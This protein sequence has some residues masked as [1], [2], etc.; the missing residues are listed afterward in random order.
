MTKEDLQ[1]YLKLSGGIALLAGLSL[2]AYAIIAPGGLHAA[3]RDPLAFYTTDEGQTLFTAPASRI[4]PF[5]HNA[6]PAVA[7][8][9]TTTDN[10]K[11]RSVAYLQRYN[12]TTRKLLT[13]ANGDKVPRTSGL[14]VK[15]PGPSNPWVPLNSKAGVD[16]LRSLT[17]ARIDP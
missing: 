16:I 4:P 7:A 15:K 14:E 3:A 10:G 5:D 11:T 6:A 9:V 17:G 8:V 1:P 13:S 12:E 2:S